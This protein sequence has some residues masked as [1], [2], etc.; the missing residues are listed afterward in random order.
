MATVAV[1]VGVLAVLHVLEILEPAL[2][3]AV[4]RALLADAELAGGLLSPVALVVAIMQRNDESG[5]RR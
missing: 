1:V 3:G 5:P 4:R 2:S